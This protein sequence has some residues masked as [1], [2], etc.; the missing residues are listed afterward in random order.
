VVP[1]RARS[2]G[3][4]AAGFALAAAVIY[5]LP[6]AF[7][8]AYFAHLFQTI[9]Y[10]TIVVIGLNVLI[11][12]SGQVSLGHAGFFGIGAYTSALLS[13][14]AGLSLLLTFPA[15]VLASAL[16]GLVLALPAIRA[17]G[18]YLAVITM[19]FGFVVEILSQRWVNLTG[20]TM[21]VYGIPAVS[22]FGEPLGA[23]GFFYLVAGAALAVQAATSRLLRSMWGRTLIAVK[24]SEEAAEAVGVNVLRWKVMA[25]VISAAWAGLG[26]AFFA[27]QNGFINSD[28]FTFSS[29]LF[30]LTALIVGG[31]GHDW[32]P[33]VGVLVLTLLNQVSAQLF[34]Y[35]FFTL[36]AL[37]LGVLVFMPRG[38]AG[39]AATLARRLEHWRRR[40]GLAP[41]Q[42]EGDGGALGLAG[43]IGPDGA[44]ALEVSGL[45]KHF[46]GVAAVDGVDL[47]VAAGRIHA[48]IGPNG[49]GKSTTVNLVTGHLPAD[50]GQV[51]CA[52]AALEGLA[53][54]GRARLGLVRTFQNLQFFP[55]LTVAENVMVGCHRHVRATLLEF[56]LGLPRARRDEAASVRR[57]E[58]ILRALGLLD[59]A[60]H[61][62]DEISYGH[63]KLVELGRALA[64]EPRVLLLDEPVAG[65]SATEAERI[66]QLLDELRAA[67]MT[68]LLIEHNMDF[69][70][71]ISDRVTV[72]NFGQKIAEGTPAE[73]QR[74]ARVLDA[75]LGRRRGSLVGA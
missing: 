17:K 46:G 43:A 11:G 2:A 27:H 58:A 72:L 4:Q 35:R 50:G 68:I 37:L 48:L 8:T 53:A 34:E 23:V 69:V 66:R 42:A 30:F 52:G 16:A 60:D 24:D 20:G 32:G 56:A 10:Y 61:R 25:F 33:L 44:A 6:W 5:V 41:V 19:A 73:I 55:D 51:R 3:R 7:P 40:A 1:K 9:A 64:A 45:R 21:G 28:S 59:L 67:G 57:T 29:S 31:L 71:K 38:I 13:T 65:L 18:L 74:D 39:G 26:G 63:R 36:G 14:K 75:Y 12:F 22:W 49:A 15:A 54:H 70:M 47:A 62:P